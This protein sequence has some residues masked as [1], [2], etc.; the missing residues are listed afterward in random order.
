MN[1]AG[2]AEMAPYYRVITAASEL[3]LDQALLETM[4]KANKL[5]LEKLDARLAEAEQTEGESD[6]ADALQARANYFTK[7]GERVRVSASQMLSSSFTH[8]R[9]PGESN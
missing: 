2:T 8:T 1:A 3:P 4:D 6:I 9:A 5:E 7:I